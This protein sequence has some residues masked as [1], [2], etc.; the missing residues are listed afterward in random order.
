MKSFAK[1]EKF[2]KVSDLVEHVISCDQEDEQQNLSELLENAQSFL[3]YDSIVNKFLQ[4]NKQNLLMK[5]LR[6]DGLLNEIE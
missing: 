2:L 5:I 4:R 3:D 1:D 6:Q